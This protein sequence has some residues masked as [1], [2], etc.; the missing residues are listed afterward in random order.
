MC[1]SLVK[2]GPSIA[3]YNFITKLMWLYRDV[4][5]KLIVGH[6]VNFVCP[7][8]RLSIRSSAHSL[9]IVLRTDWIIDFSNN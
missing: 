5:L 9:H 6:S 4:C 8:F 3:K 7:F 1:C 2:L